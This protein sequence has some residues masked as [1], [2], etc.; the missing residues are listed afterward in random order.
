MPLN[1]GNTM[2]E[3]FDDFYNFGRF[4]PAINARKPTEYALKKY[5]GKLPDKLLEYW[6]LYGWSGYADGLFWTVD[7]SEWEDILEIWIGGTPFIERD[8]YHV[9][10]RT[11]FGD[12]FLWGE[13]TGSS[14]HILTPWGM[15][16]PR[17]QP[18]LFAERGA[19]RS[20]QLFFASKGRD[21]LELEDYL[22]KPLFERA[23]KKLGPLDHDTMYGFVP[24]LAMSGKPQLEHLQ[25]LDA[26]THLEILAQITPRRIMQDIVALSKQKP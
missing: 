15:I 5:K 14:L 10:A 11:A 22:K 8:A 12:L 20:L 23:L 16:F 13:T 3:F 2:D 9:I 17:F 18:D 6:Q 25:K 7:P 1:E 4:G 19:D 24:A 26:K 21:R